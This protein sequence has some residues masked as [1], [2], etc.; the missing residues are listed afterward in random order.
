MMKCCRIASQE[1]AR[2]HEQS[3]ASPVVLTWARN[4]S[5]R[6]SCHPTVH[7][8]CAALFSS[9]QPPPLPSP[10][11]PAKPT[12][13]SIFP[14][15]SFWVQNHHR[16]TVPPPPG[17]PYMDQF[18]NLVSRVRKADQ[19]KH[20][21]RPTHAVCLGDCGAFQS[22]A[23]HSPPA[24]LRILSMVRL[25]A[26]RNRYTSSRKR[27]C[28]PNQRAGAPLARSGFLTAGRAGT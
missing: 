20:R 21:K 2:D 23:S 6:G 26:R 11:S 3:A 10:H 28:G 22:V 13:D 12:A 14:V 16:T 4:R 17:H 19:V 5:H 24:A 18:G 7:S 9:P 8:P 25:L 27:S 15:R 1:Q